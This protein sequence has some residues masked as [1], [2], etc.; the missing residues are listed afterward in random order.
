MSPPQVTFCN[1][2]MSEQWPLPVYRQDLRSFDE[3]YFRYFHHCRVFSSSPIIGRLSAREVSP[4]MNLAVSTRTGNFISWILFASVL[5]DALQ[6]GSEFSRN[7]IRKYLVVILR[8][9][10]SMYCTLHCVRP[11]TVYITSKKSR[12][13]YD[14]WYCVTL[15]MTWQPLWLP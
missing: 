10:S 13:F 2:D 4:N 9:F 14:C 15:L 6:S 1:F 11:Y 7:C 5:S 12:V 3:I 8:L